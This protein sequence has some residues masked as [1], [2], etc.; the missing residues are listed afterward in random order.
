[1]QMI[2]KMDIEVSRWREIFP[3]GGEGRREELRVGGIWV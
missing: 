1:M 2:G 3:G